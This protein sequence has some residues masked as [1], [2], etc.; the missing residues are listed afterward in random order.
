MNS[1][2]ITWRLIDTGPLAG[3][4]NMAVDEAL[5]D[6][7]DPDTSLPVLR[8]YGW[9][10]PALSLGRYQQAAE[11]LDLLSKLADKSLVSVMNWEEGRYRLLE[12]IWQY[13]NEKLLASGDGETLGAR[14]LEFFLKLAEETEPHFRDTEQV[15]WF[16]RLMA[17]HDNLLAALDWSLKGSGLTAALRLTAALWYFWLARDYYTPGIKRLMQVLALTETAPPFEIMSAPF[18]KK[19]KSETA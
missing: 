12:P 16:N 17:E 19:R 8:L 3:A 9:T 10:P 18:F 6:C 4:D 15:T 2:K 5:L 11:V 7:F 14:H 13:A 1:A